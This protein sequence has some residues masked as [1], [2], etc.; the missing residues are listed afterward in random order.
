MLS[1][2]LAEMGEDPTGE[3]PGAGTIHLRAITTDGR[4][5]LAAAPEE[6]FK[7]KRH[8]LWEAFYA[9]HMVITALRTLPLNKTC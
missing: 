9:G 1:K 4:R 2:H 3:T 7:Q 8:P 6:D 5:L